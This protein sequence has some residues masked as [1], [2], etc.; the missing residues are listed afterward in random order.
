MTKIQQAERLNG[1]TRPGVAGERVMEGREDRRVEEGRLQGK[2]RTDGGS[3]T[4]DSVCV[5]V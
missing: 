3:E 5:C 4:I 1:W 2:M